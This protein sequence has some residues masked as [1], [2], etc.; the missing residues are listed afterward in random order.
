ML[1][2]KWVFRRK[3]AIRENDTKFLK[4]KARLVTRDFQHLHG[5]DYE[6]AFSTVVKDSTLRMILAI[7]AFEN[8]ELHQ[9]DVK[10]VFLNGGL[11]GDIYMMQPKGFVNK[12]YP[13][14]VCKLV[15]ALYGLKHA[16]RKWFEKMNTFPCCFP[17]FES[18]PYDPSFYVIQAEKDL[19]MT[20]LYVGD[21]LIAGRPVAAVLEIK[22]NL[23]MMFEIEGCGEAKVCQALEITRNR[24]QNSLKTSQ[25]AYLQEVILR[26]GMDDTKS[27]YTPTQS[28][29]GVSILQDVKSD[30]TVYSK[31]IGSLM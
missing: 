28:Q 31:A 26:F 22:K 15:K 2:C 17:G 24:E 14:H 12:D 5:I 1:T 10:T 23:S 29:I 3:D 25:V 18:C 11:N 20:T 9:M 13:E 4:Y 21:L 16:P 27:V 7:V 8:L 30:S 6:E 19:I